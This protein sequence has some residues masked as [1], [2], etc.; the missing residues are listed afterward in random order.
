MANTANRIKKGK[1][2]T[3]WVLGAT[4]ISCVVMAIIAMAIGMSIYGTDLEREY[5][6]RATSVAKN[7][8]ASVLHGQPRTRGLAE[9]VMGIYYSL[10]P[11]QQMKAVSD[12]PADRAEYRS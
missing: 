4:V 11:E 6:N 2:L 9:Q 12:D 7:A 1:S 3:S 10:T 8:G 5:I